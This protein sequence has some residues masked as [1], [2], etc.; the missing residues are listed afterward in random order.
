MK[1]IT[2]LKLVVDQLL[3]S[4]LV[5]SEIALNEL[6]IVV[7]AAHIEEVML[8]LRDDQSTLFEQCVDMCGVDYLEYG[9]NYEG[10]RF[11]LIYSLLSI[12]KNW[13]LRVKVFLKDANFPVIKSLISVWSSLNWLEREAFDLMGIL[14]DSHPDLR[15]IL[16]DY[17]FVG[18]PL[19]KDF[20][21]SG[22]VE[23]R[24]D[25]EEKRILY[26]PVSIE[27]REII[28]RVIHE[29]SYNGGH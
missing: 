24:Y 11:A 13:R 20:P 19:R 1:K 27:P 8:K 5:F 6:T 14:F 29:E 17:G 10:D 3:G 12:T 23:M 4:K 16:T 22:Y 26:Q 9:N 7:E 15:R 25:E 28:S 18:H 2:E 21:L